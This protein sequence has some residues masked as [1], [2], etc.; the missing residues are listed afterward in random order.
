MLVLSR[1][2]DE[3]VVIT[4]PPSSQEQVVELVVIDVRGDKVR[5]GIQADEVVAVHRREV[6]DAIDRE[7]GRAPRTAFDYGPIAPWPPTN[8]QE[9]RPAA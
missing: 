3:R 8:P 1:H 4:V 6:Q 5:L 2:R 7:A 9:G